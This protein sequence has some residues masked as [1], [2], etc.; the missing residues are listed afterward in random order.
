MRE[1]ILK[2]CKSIPT[3]NLVNYIKGGH[4]SLSELIAAGLPDDK[5]QEIQI[6]MEAED[7]ASWNKAK[8]SETLD[9]YR[10]YTSSYPN[11]NH[12]IEAKT[13]IDYYD[14]F[15]WD[16]VKQNISES[17]LKSYK[18]QFPNG[19]H[20]SE[21]HSLLNDLPWIKACE[22]NTIATYEEYRTLYPSKHSVEV[23]KLIN[24]LN[25]DKDWDNA[26]LTG[27]TDA[28][29]RYI[30]QHS[31]GKHADDAQ[32]KIQ[33]RA[34]HD[35]FL[36]ALK[37]D[38]NS[39]DAHEIQVRVGNNVISWDDIKSVF[40]EDKMNAIKGFRLPSPL[41]QKNP[42]SKLQGNSTEVYFWGTPS[43]GKTCA[44][45]SIISSAQ[46]MGI[47]EK[48]NCSGYNYMTR[49]SNIFCKRGFCT[50]P[51]STS[52]NNIQE[53]ILKLRDEKSKQHKLTLIDLAGELF[54]SVFSIQNGLFLS[55]E[56][57]D[58]LNVALKY[59][60]D[61]RNEKIHFFVVE[62]GAHD[63]E[64]EGLKMVNYLDNM[65]SFLK[66]EK[67][68]KKST[69]GVYVLVTKCDKIDCFKKEDRPKLA[70][71]YVS[72][73]MPS[74]WNNLKN[75]CKE[76]SVGD[77]K[78]LSFSVGD[79]FAKNL[80]KFEGEDTIKVIDKLITKTDAEGGFWNW[81]RL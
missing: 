40:G 4:V 9:S 74:F 73:E 24:D 14:D 27:T 75:T 32:A 11:G 33:A 69:V 77:L 12:T 19:K 67:I 64:W 76:A 49:L 55:Q 80:C 63:K 45:G 58:T 10:L 81:L 71:E 41:P 8:T 78:V 38:A 7:E 65:I 23:D 62:Y 48:I 1:R 2:G 21:C 56:M 52:V 42:P 31:N 70:Y 28:F 39:Y 44:L 22:I 25:D 26:C 30:D 60:T 13:K 61:S 43:S 35:A 36:N 3:K 20:V 53:M 37:A 68:F 16:H 57:T 47:L 66:K 59:L 72:Q 34:G 50:F 15:N 17:T 51:D 5:L 6:L 54:R 46:S 18:E 79:V 29:K